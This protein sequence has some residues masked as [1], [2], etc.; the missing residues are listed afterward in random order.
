MNDSLSFCVQKYFNS[1]LLKQKNYGP[2][3]TASYSTTFS[4][5]LEFLKTVKEKNVDTLTLN[6]ID[7]ETVIEFIQWLKEARTSSEATCNVRLAHIRSFMKYI[8]LEIPSCMET[9]SKVL[10][11]P[12]QKVTKM[13]PEALE[14]DFI[15]KLLVA[16][17]T[18]TMEG[19]RHTA[20]LSLLYD[21]GCRVQELIDLTVGDITF[22]TNAKILV[23]G[24]GNKYR[25]IPVLSP[26]AK[27][28]K[29][30]MDRFTLTSPEMIFF[31]SKN[32]GKMTRQGVRYILAKYVDEVKKAFPEMKSLDNVHPHTMRH[33]KATHLVNANIH[34]FNVRD[35]LGHKSVQT[36]QVYLT[37]NLEKKREALEKASATIGITNETSYSK[38]KSNELEE[39]LKSM[40]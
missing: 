21:S 9:C 33:S 12:L 5:L 32:G 15:K 20:L 23:R 6:D 14:E 16:P 35:F 22:G 10:Q 36:T 19:I 18:K 30:Y 40:K 39:F 17:G 8:M 7:K 28:L 26:T 38:E 37:S 11:I 29:V 34:I 13:P 4:L 3:T 25:T 1:Y 2:N 27:L 24:K 31:P